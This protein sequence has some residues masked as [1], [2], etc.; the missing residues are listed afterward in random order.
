MINVLT[1]LLRFRIAFC[2][3]QTQ[4]RLEVTVVNN[5]MSC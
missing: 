4:H 3:E 2:R 5:G 1:L